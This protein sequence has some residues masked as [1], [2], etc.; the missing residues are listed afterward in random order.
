M[1]QP[2]TVEQRMTNLEQAW[3]AAIPR[4]TGVEQGLAA[5]GT[6]LVALEQAAQSFASRVTAVEQGL[7]AG[8]QAIAEMRQTQEALAARM[9][10]IEASMNALGQVARP[11]RT[12]IRTQLSDL[13]AQLAEV[14]S[15]LPDTTPTDPPVE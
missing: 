12:V 7:A 5:G 9:T 4:L 14:L 1:T 11:G 3:S 2:L 8:G 6:R 10:A 13:Q 15:R